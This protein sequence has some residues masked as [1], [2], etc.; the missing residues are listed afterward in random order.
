MIASA[1][2]SPIPSFLKRASKNFVLPH[3][4]WATK[5]MFST[6]DSKNGWEFYSLIIW[7]VKGFLKSDIER[8]SIFPENSLYTLHKLSS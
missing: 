8:F 6:I 5:R 4:R 3:Q 7:N 2:H 1:S